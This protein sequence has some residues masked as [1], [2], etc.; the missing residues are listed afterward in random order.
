M[1]RSGS[2]YSS[3]ETH[4]HLKPASSINKIQSNSL[5]LNSLARQVQLG[6]NKHISNPTSAS[7]PIGPRT[8]TFHSAATKVCPHQDLD[9]EPV[10]RHSH[11]PPP[12]S[13]PHSPSPLQNWVELQVLKSRGRLL[14]RASGRLYR[15]QLWRS[16][17]RESYFWNDKWGWR[18]DKKTT[19]VRRMR[20]GME[21]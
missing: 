12:N 7:H 16:M 4:W 21:N 9:T 14:A 2:D 13:S 17:K 15:R 3:C 10:L 6:K 18:R 20:M 8:P 19:R 5:S 1:N 11:S